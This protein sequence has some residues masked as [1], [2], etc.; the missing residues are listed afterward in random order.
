MLSSVTLSRHTCLRIFE[1]KVA[2][3]FIPPGRLGTNPGQLVRVLEI[4]LLRTA[5]AQVDTE[6]AAT[7][8]S[9]LVALPL[10][11]DFTLSGMCTPRWCLVAIAPPPTGVLTALTVCVGSDVTALSHINQL[12]TLR[13]LSI[14]YASH[15]EDTTSA[16]RMMAAT[17]ALTLRT[18]MDIRLFASDCP[19]SEAFVHYVARC[20]F[21]STS[22]VYL[23]FCDVGAALSGR[24]AKFLDAHEFSDVTLLLSTSPGMGGYASGS[25]VMCIAPLT[26]CLL[27]RLPV[28]LNWPNG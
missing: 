6:L 28:G 21:H 20:R 17:E 2:R 9:I 15:E 23:D 1:R 18:V 27:Y 11:K 25:N 5:L 22:R 10:L 14:E 13:R 26:N 3:R 8:V 16:I 24:L 12:K 7:I 4:K 19:S